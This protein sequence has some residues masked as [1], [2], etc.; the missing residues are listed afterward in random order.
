MSATSIRRAAAFLAATGLALLA[1]QSLHAQGQRDSSVAVVVHPDV[2][3]T[4]L[5]LQEV[6]SVFLGDRQYWNSKLPVVLLIR[7]PVAHERDVVLRVI[8][9][10]S[11]VQFKRYWIAKIFRAESATPPKIVYSNDM[12][13]E[14]TAAIPGAIAFLDSQDVRPGVKVVRVDGY[15]P[16]EP[17][18]P[19]K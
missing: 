9:E 15:L 17:G 11:E 2:P 18:Y 16:G 4:N 7:A 10:M 14:L 6:R 19:L 1:L 13:N 8:Y 5:S 12:T 3:V